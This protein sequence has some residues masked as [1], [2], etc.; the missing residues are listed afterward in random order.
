MVLDAETPTND[1]AKKNNSVTLNLF[2][3]LNMFKDKSIR[4]SF[5]GKMTFTT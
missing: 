1:K 5:Y 4:V 2:Q 3:D